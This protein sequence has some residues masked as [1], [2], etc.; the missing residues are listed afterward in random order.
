MG[1]R[2]IEICGG[3]ASGKTTLCKLLQERGI[4]SLFDEY[5]KN[6]FWQIPASNYAKCA[7][8]REVTFLLQHYHQIKT[9]QHLDGVVVCDFSLLEAHAYAKTDLLP[10]QLQAYEA[11]FFHVSQEL[12]PPALLV[13]LCCSAK[14]QMARLHRRGRPQE[15]TVSFDRLSM[16]MKT[17][18]KLVLELPDEFL[19]LT[20]NSERRDFLQD[21]LEKEAVVGAILQTVAFPQIRAS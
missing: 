18:E 3:M 11:I 21:I 15:L 19:V 14:E 16:L 20:I 2:R 1:P 4:E 6:P 9:T 12:G 8:E 7:F 10:D 17:V 5:W 13:H